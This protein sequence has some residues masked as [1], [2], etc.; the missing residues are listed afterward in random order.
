MPDQSSISSY[1][2]LLFV[3]PGFITVWSFRHVGSIKKASDFEYF[4]LSV[5]WGL[6]ML[7]IYELITPLEMVQKLLQNLYAAALILSMIGFLF[8]WIGGRFVKAKKG[9]LLDAHRTCLAA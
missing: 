8:G 5:F 6:V 7:L 9:A 4:A 1:M 2:L 3:I